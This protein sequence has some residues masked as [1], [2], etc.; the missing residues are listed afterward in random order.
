MR[1]EKIRLKNVKDEEVDERRAFLKDLR[2]IIAIDR[3]DWLVKTAG[4]DEYYTRTWYCTPE[5]IIYIVKK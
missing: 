2:K 4:N 5:T 3:K 1:I